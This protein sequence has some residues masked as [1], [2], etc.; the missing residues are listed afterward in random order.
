MPFLS[1]TPI[2]SHAHVAIIGAGPRGTSVLER[3]CASVR[4][5]LQP[6]GQLTIHVVDPSTPGSG[7]VWRTNQSQELLMNTV[8]GQITLFTDDS[9]VCSGPIR[10]GPSMYEWAAM[11]PSSKLGP[12]D[13]PSR[14]HYG[15]YL[16]WIFSETVRN[17]PAG[18][19]VK[20]HKARAVRLDDSSATNQAL[21]LSNGEI[22]SDLNSVVLAQ[23][24]VPLQ[25]DSQLQ[26]LTMYAKANGLNHIQPVNPADVDL[27]CI[28]P[29]DSV[30]LR[31]LGL[32]FCDFMA[33][34]TTGRGGRFERTSK[35]LQ[36]IPSGQEP[37]LYACSRRGVPSQ[38]RGDNAKGAYGRHMPYLL[39]ED[40]INGFRNRAESGNPPDFLSEVWPLV[41]KEV[42]TVYY[43]CLLG[44]S[45]CKLLNFR[46]RFLASRHGSSEETQLLNH[47]GMPEDLRWSWERIQ[48]PFTGRS[49]KSPSEWRTWLLEYLR[50]DVKEATLGNVEGP[51]KAALDIMRDLRNEL[52]L[53]V[54]HRGI[55]GASR[56][57][58]LDRWYT[59]LNAFLSIGPPRIRVEQ[60]VALIE[61]GVLDI[62]GPKPEVRAEGGAWLAN[63]P[64]VPGSEVRVTTIIEARLPEPSLRH[65]GD[66]LLAH[67]F[68]TGQCREHVVDGY[69][70]GGLD[71]TDAPYHLID[72]VGHP[73]EA[74][75]ALGVPTE[76]VHW[77]TA[78]GA[79][80]GVNSVTLC[81]TDHVA[82]AALK[83]A[84]IKPEEVKTKA[85]LTLKVSGRVEQETGNPSKS[86]SIIT[87]SEI[88][89]LQT[90]QA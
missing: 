20:V 74:R 48:R 39:T 28:A 33:L 4:D 61:A 77:V 5:F 83:S 6:G 25:V 19:D 22:I 64:E 84:L 53:I 62:L 7:A 43:E 31:G 12:D 35:G 41:A 44:E 16:E 58:H 70:T 80:P 1:N 68:T 51:L 72:A 85:R 60:M 66:Q 46:S 89:P 24:H 49:F 11:D 29:G 82:R 32:N 23:G 14:A 26:Q 10:R 90:V 87:P 8:A 56:R 34:L 63:S 57:D 50:E 17:A 38:A 78:A 79:R 71:V 13:Y 65:T 21:E 45:A 27:S 36:Y 15:Q 3:I 67:L 69:A 59:P 88:N 42:E 40:V 81:D 18:V 2:T 9:V 55:S 86:V 76:G 52:R 30:L 37:H 75:F 73:H 47:L 54:D